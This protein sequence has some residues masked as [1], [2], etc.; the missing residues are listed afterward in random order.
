MSEFK[1]SCPNCQQNIAATSEYCGLQI[2]CPGCNAAITVP[3][4]PEAP[5]TTASPHKN[6]LSMAPST[7]QHANTSTVMAAATVRKAK[8]PRYG[9]YIGLGCGAL[10]AVA[11][12]LL[13]PK[14]MDKYHQ[15]QEVVAAEIK[16]TNTPPPPPPDLSASEILQKMTA[17]YKAYT[18]YSADGESVSTVDMSAISPALTTPVETKTKISVRLARPSLYRLEWEKTS[19][20]GAKTI[21]GSVWSAGS[22]DFLKNGS[23]SSRMKNRETALATAG[24]YS[25][26]MSPVIASLF[27][28]Q[29][30]SMSS[31]FNSF[32]KTN[33]ETLDNHKCY[34]LTGHLGFQNLHI[35]VHKDDFLIPRLEVVLGGKMDESLLANLPA[36]QKAQM[37]KMEKIKGNIT[38]TY[39]EISTNQTMNSDAFQSAIPI[40]PNQPTQHKVKRDSRSPR[41][42]RQ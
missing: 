41:G 23:A 29:N 15:H 40:V 30:D 11:A 35:W 28:N 8:K 32:S 33:N 2:N 21:Q 22:G 19:A 13:I 5:P 10:A 1:F 25:G 6:K 3:D 31:V 7:V 39:S 24:S 26:T 9:L 17:A 27:F 42:S 12:I 20:T 37:Q 4:A 36:A 16:A 34:V 38:E 18:S 14:A